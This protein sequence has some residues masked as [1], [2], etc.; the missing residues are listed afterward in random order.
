MKK[1]MLSILGRNGNKDVVVK[2]S[3]FPTRFLC[4]VS[5][6]FISDEWSSVRNKIGR[7][8][9]KCGKTPNLMGF[10]LIELLV[11]VLIIGILAAVA[12]PQY[13]M[14]VDKARLSNLVSMVQSVVKAEESYYL[15]NNEYTTDWDSL[16]VSF[17]GTPVGGRPGAIALSGGIILDLNLSPKDLVAEDE[18]L[19]GVAL[20]AFYAHG[21][22]RNVQSPVGG[23]LA[24][25][26]LR[27]SARAQQLCKQV[28]HRTT[29]NSSAGTG[30]Q[31]AD[32][33][34]F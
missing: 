6:F 32:V 18:K 34:Y 14:A 10:T 11:V 7:C 31:L 16:A 27:S 33:Y 19:P 22:E 20:Y 2:L 9:I 24:C 13:K 28:T 1:Q 12:L 4:G 26:A 17:S 3:C 8:R 5:R 25:Y 23:G 30:E 29:R 15:A 21:N